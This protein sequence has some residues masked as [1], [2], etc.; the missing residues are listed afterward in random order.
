MTYGGCKNGEKLSLSIQHP[1]KYTRLQHPD[2][3]LLFS[4][5]RTQQATALLAKDVHHPL[6]EWFTKGGPSTHCPEGV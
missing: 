3:S 2:K 1:D 4:F 6:G 5:H